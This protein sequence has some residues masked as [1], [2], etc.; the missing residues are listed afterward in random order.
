MNQNEA[1]ATQFAAFARMVLD[2][3]HAV[4]FDALVMRRNSEE[5]NRQQEQIIARRAYDLVQ[6]AMLS[7]GPADLD[8]LTTE[9]CVQRVPDLAE[10]SVVEGQEEEKENQ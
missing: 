3:L 7:I 4:A 10:L 2:E 8:M 1:R 9:E 6:H 5:L